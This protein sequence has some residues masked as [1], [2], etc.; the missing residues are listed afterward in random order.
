MLV[1]QA[2]T[3]VGHLA[4]VTA[5]ALPALQLARAAA[6]PA[7]IEAAFN[8]INRLVLLAAVLASVAL[9]AAR[10]FRLAS[11]SIVLRLGLVW[12]FFV[13]FALALVETT[14][15]S[16]ADGPAL[17]IS[18]VGPWIL[19]VNGL[20]ANRPQRALMAAL[21]AATAWP[22]A[23][24]VNAARGLAATEIDV[25]LLWP[26]LNYAMAGLAWFLGPATEGPAIQAEASEDLGGYR[27]ESQIGEG[28][29]G[30]VW[31]ASHKLLPRTAAVKIIR[32]EVVEQENRAADTAAARFR[33][34]ANVIAKLQSPHTVFLYDF[35]VATDG[36]FYY[37]MEMLE[38]ISLQALVNGSGPLPPGRAV[39]VLSQT[40]ESL[41]EA[42]ERGLVHRDLKPSNIML[43]QIALTY[44]FVKVLD[45]GLAKTLGDSGMTQLT[46][47][48]TATGT[49]GYMAPEI[50][51][52]EESIDRRADVYALG[53]VAYFLLTGTTVF[54]E[55][56]PTRMALKHVQDV[57]DAPSLRSGAAIP[58]AL[59][60]LVMQCLE[61][62]PDDRPAS[63]AEVAQRLAQS[64]VEPWTA[65]DAAAWW[66]AHE[67][68]TKDQAPGSKH[69][70][71]ERRA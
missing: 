41:H 1:E 31:K 7:L 61:K 69:Q 14:R 55:E 5:V 33:R 9:F 46:M 49:P 70:T 18:A 20:V 58:P 36:R 47:A 17:G 34:E 32:P 44:D 11:P 57:P 43:C 54:E 3:R 42:H 4:L 48:G 22:L 56:N 26:L 8:P 65:A 52:A 16:G 10:Q 21:A 59:E 62:Q 25:W 38:G 63:M 68:G 53:C 28:G 39:H 6:Q 64:G 40:C 24:A 29:M 45:F 15:P 19:I 60:S 35:G 71:T 67:A 23:Y 13:A 50:A 2:A 51:L 27:L 37:V 12:Q 66:Q 30:E